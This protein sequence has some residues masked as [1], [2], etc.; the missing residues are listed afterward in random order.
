MKPIEEIIKMPGFNIEKL[1]GLKFEAWIENEKCEGAVSIDDFCEKLCVHLCQ[2]TKSGHE[3]RDKKG[4]IYSW[5]VYDL[6]N[7]NHD[8]VTNLKID[9]SGVDFGQYETENVEDEITAAINL[10]KS[11]GYRVLKQDWI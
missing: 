6:K 2:N 10:L 5:N 8:Y 3:C 1:H 7:P 9:I 11:K 4:Y